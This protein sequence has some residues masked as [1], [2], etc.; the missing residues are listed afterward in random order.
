MEIQETTVTIEDFDKFEYYEDLFD[1][2]N[3][4]RQ[5]RR[6]RKPRVNSN[7]KKTTQEI[8]TDV[9]ETRGVEGGFT[10]TYQPARYERGWL[11]NSLS[12]FYEEELI[13]DVLAQVK[14][15]KEASVYRCLGHPGSG[16][17]LLAAKV[18]RPR[19]FR[20]LRNDGMYREGRQI[21]TAEGRGMKPTDERILRALAKKTA[22]GAEVQHTS[23]LMHEYVA[24]EQLHKA[25]GAVPQPLAAGD[26]AILMGYCGDEYSAA[27]TLQQVDL[28]PTEVESLFQEVLRNIDLMLQHNFVHGDLSA[29]NILYWQGKITLIDFPQVVDIHANKKAYF[30]LQRDL[31]RVC[32]YF[33]KQGLV[34]NPEAILS[35]MWQRYLVSNE[36]NRVADESRLMEEAMEE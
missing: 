4:D 8:I 19:Q 11:L 18:Y 31:T 17:A 34:R 30:I 20:N 36:E 16:Q 27:P 15:G 10:P 33:A 1:P 12:P 32:E 7:P 5:A 26:N 22:F 23:W 35:D 24:L 13:T 25:G 14:G 28:E 2:I 3:T 9:G 21:L 6:K 29:F